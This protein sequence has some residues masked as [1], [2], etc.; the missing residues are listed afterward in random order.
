[1]RRLTTD[2]L[3]ATLTIGAC[4][5]VAVLFW[6]GYRA[7]EEWRL[8]SVLLA[9]RQSSD[10]ADLLVTA[11]TRD[12]GG[13]QASILTSPQ[14]NQFTADH[15]HE[16]NALVASTFA[17]YPYPEAFFAWRSG[18]PYSEAVLF[19]RAARRPPWAAHPETAAVF[20][21]VT[22]HEPEAARELFSQIALDAARGKD[23]SFFEGT[24]NNTRCQ[25]VAQLIYSDNYRQQLSSVV[26]FTVNLDWIESHYFSE[27]TQQVWSIGH[28]AETGLAMHIK[29]A[30]G[31]VVAGSN[32]DLP[33]PLSHRRSFDLLFIEAQSAFPVSS[34]FVP[35]KWSV[36]VSGADSTLLLRDSV[37]AN[38]VLA[39]AAVSSLLFALGL[40]M[41][42]RAAR[43]NTQLTTMRSDFVSAV[44]H[45]LKTPIATIKAAAETLAKDRL[46]GMSVTT[47]GRIVVMESN[48]LARLVE[49]LLAYARITDVSDSYTF[50]TVEVAAIF[51]DIQQDFEARLDHQGFELH[52]AISA[53]VY[54]VSGDRFALR[55]LFGNLLDNAI[56]Y[57]S[58]RRVISLRASRTESQVRID[59]EDQGVGIAADEIPKVMRKFVRAREATGGG[60]GLGLSI[61]SRIAKDHQGD[62]TIVSE[63][64]R[65]TTVT[66]TLPVAN[67]AVEHVA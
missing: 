24:L 29:N 27:L 56:K 25:V 44:T 4:V 1:V 38:R 62:L 16:M 36:V 20:P 54:A 40:I 66:V 21:V 63:V 52:V 32:A 30:A 47:C 14:W 9:D 33:G 18:A 58:E 2:A 49:N 67:R 35:E 43:T 31:R 11:L 8:K 61:A 59:V 45:E 17:R 37:A 12:M 60:S 64:G 55:L 28:G 46:T 5:S 39:F 23:L 51:N 26:G 48:R 6:F 13:V 22:A 42:A 41:I 65:G 19:Y 50:E 10:A 34:N 7:V 3:T 53:G 57:S 15:P